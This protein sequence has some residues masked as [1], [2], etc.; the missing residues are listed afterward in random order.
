MA[1]GRTVSRLRIVLVEDSSLLRQL[2]CGILGEMDGVDVVGVA[3]DEAT[4]LRTLQE[5]RTDLAIVD[6]QLESGSG[7]GV[8]RALKREPERFGRPV[9]VVF[10]NY[11]HAQ[12]HERCLALGV[13]RF[14][15]K[16]L[17]MNEL[18]DYVEAARQAI[19]G[20]R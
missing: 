3:A 18:I 12:L 14:F 15:D 1:S 6:L 13:D 17:Q 2:L 10:S 5:Q 4:A 16:A 9:A 11:G 20:D 7:L 19:A 8:L